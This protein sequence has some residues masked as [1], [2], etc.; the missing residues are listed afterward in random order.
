MSDVPSVLPTSGTVRPITR[1]GEP[2]MHRTQEPITEFG[3]DLQAGRARLE[4]QEGEEPVVLVRADALVGLGLVEARVADD[5]R[6]DVGPVGEQRLEQPLVLPQRRGDR[7]QQR[8]F[9]LT[10]SLA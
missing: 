8:R 6:V 1:W 9:A 4:Q 10:S 7:A 2:V 3:E 5:L